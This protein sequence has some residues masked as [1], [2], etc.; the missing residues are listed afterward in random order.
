MSIKKTIVTQNAPPE[1]LLPWLTY[2]GFLTKKLKKEASDARLERIEQRWEP[3]DWW[4]RCVLKRQYEQVLHR[5]IIMWA[6][7]NPCWYARTIIPH[8]T[9]E[10]DTALF[11]RLKNESLG[12]LIFSSVN[13]NRC[14]MI[15]YPINAQSIEYHWL[16]KELRQKE[17]TFWLRLSEFSVHDL[18]PF[19]LV[20]IFL[21]GLKRALER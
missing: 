20:E 14:K 21:P 5:N 6:F 4:D 9:Y 8:T 1:F 18:W 13:I 12:H 19:F 17:S 15:H 11:D 2:T 16:N 10:T 7:D 3:A